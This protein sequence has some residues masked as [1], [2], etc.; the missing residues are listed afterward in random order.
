MTVRI[1]CLL[2]LALACPAVAD[3]DAPAKA[4][5][6][7]IL[8]TFP[9]P[10]VGRMSQPG[11]VRPAY[12]RR[13]SGYLASASVRRKAKRI[14]REFNLEIIDEWPIVALQIHC[15]VVA[16]D[17]SEPVDVL[18]ERLNARPEVESAQLLNEFEVS[19]AGAGHAPD[20]YAKLQHNHDLL[21][22]REAHGWSLGDGADIT[23]IDTGADLAHPE[24][25][26]QIRAHR[27][28]VAGNHGAFSTDAHGTAIAGVIAAS[29]DNGV[30]MIG[31]APAARLTVLR[32]CWYAAGRQAA[33]CDS[34]TLAKA[35]AYAVD[36]ETEIINLSLGGP[37]D[38]LLARLV[39]VALER[40]IVVVAA[41]PAGRQAGFPADVPGVIVVSSAPAGGATHA[42]LHAPG[43]EILVPV[44]GGGFDYASGNSLSAAQ[45]SGIVA[46]LVAMDPRLGRERIR[47][48]LARSQDL[49][50]GTVNACHALSRLL[51]RGG[52]AG[53][54]VARLP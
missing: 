51:Q 42:A 41:A 20:P 3:S 26:T 25:K 29:S 45:V 36:S 19:G 5:P 23:I 50:G 34:F 32:A 53:P 14:A 49:A 1:A 15:L 24:L 39:R 4:A 2:L 40:D 21:G 10:G 12:G 30:G 37:P 31:V 13:A 17:G 33:V 16:T 43:E 48:L 38:P 8:L 54:P 27:D 22:L 6:A 18:L 11:P 35:L 44:P 47:S 28:F 46:L 9:D 52:C 7:K